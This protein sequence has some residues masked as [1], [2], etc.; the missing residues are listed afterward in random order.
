MLDNTKILIV[1]DEPAVAGLVGEIVKEFSLEPIFIYDPRRV[2][3]TFNAVKPFMVF[4]DLTMP[5]LSGVDILEK[6]KSVEPD[7][8]F[9]IMTG[10]GSIES[11]IEAIRLGATDY[12][13]KPL[14]LDLLRHLIKK[15]LDNDNLKREN[16]EL[17]SLL[18]KKEFPGI[19]GQSAVL[20][21][22]L[23]TVKK[24]APSNADIMIC[25]ES[26]TG[27]EMIARSVHK[28]SSRSSE[29]F[30]A[31]DC[32]AM[33]KS[34]FESEMFGYEKGAFT[35]AEKQRDGLLK[36]ADGGT[37]FIDEVTELDYELQ[38]KLLR[39]LQERQ[40]RRVGGHEMIDIDIRIVS[41]TRRDPLEEIS[42]GTFR[43]DL[44]Y[45]LSVIPLMLPPLRERS[46]DIAL[47][48]QAFIQQASEKNRMPVKPLQQKVIDVLEAY[49]WPGNI[50][51]L[52]NIVER[53]FI[54]SGDEVCYEDLPLNLKSSSSAKNHY[55]AD[56]SIPY[57]SGKEIIL[58]EF[59]EI[60]LNKLYNSDKGNMSK[61]AINSGL[62]RKAIYDLVKKFDIIFELSK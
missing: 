53:L 11:A 35:G 25:G 8:Q 31:V 9:V 45:R 33:P 48:V 34:L 36:Q 2:A 13:Q 51:E 42:K 27:K 43:D 5:K 46:E 49:S 38:A 59:T 4:S 50:R 61:M 47:L 32:V 16:V 26:G 14:N 19:V 20:Q 1:D 7:V 40:Y 58:R 24:V 29:P 30:V 22:L 54:L 10:Y 44:Y 12:I 15:A 17:K 37:L 28:Y 21:S 56:I 3:E 60:Y 52:K 62:S 23:E 18:E 57:K 39:V 41:A 55:N 6:C